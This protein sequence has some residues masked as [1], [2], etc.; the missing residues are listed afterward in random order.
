MADFDSLDI[1]ISAKNE[2]AIKSLK[3][4]SDSV[5][6]LSQAMSTINTGD[7]QKLSSGISALSQAS[8]GLSNIK[9]TDFNKL[10][11]AISRLTSMDSGAMNT[12]NNN[13]RSLS[14][15]IRSFANTNIPMGTQQL[16]DFGMAIRQ[17]GYK[18]SQTA[19]ETIPKLTVEIGKMI[20][21][22]SKMPKVEQSVIDMTNAMANLTNAQKGM[23]GSAKGIETPYQR[24]RNALN[25]T[26]DSMTGL[27]TKQKQLHTST[28]GLASTIGKVYA[29]YWLLF[30]AISKLGQAISIASSLTE[31]QNVVDVS[32]GKASAKLDKFASS[33]DA[34][35]K[36][37]MNELSIKTIASQF[38]AMGKAIGVSNSA[39]KETN[40]VWKDMKGLY[41]NSASS[42]ADVSMNLTKLAS[43][44]A[45]F[46]DKDVKDVSEDLQAVFTGLTRPLRKYGLDLTQT[47]LS[48]WAF[49]QGLNG[50]IKTMTNAEKTLLRYQYVMQRTQHIQSDFQKTSL[51]WHNQI[52]ILKQSFTALASII[53]Q[54]LIY[55]IKPALIGLNQLMA[56]FISVARTISDSLGTIFGWQFE[57]YNSGTTIS[58]DLDGIESGVD[59]IGNSADSSN[60]KVKK[61]KENLQGFD[62]LNVINVDDNSSG[63][64]GG[65]GSGAGSSSSTTSSSE[66]GWKKVESKF[67][68][69][70]LDTLEKLGGAISDKL[71]K[72]MDSIDWDK[73]YGR[74]K[75]FGSGLASFLNGLFKEDKDGN[76]V[77]SALGKTI[78]G[79]LNTVVYSALS[80]SETAEWGKWGDALGGGI[81]AF[82]ET[83][84]FKATANA[85][86]K[87]ADG[88]L[89]FLTKAVKKV[90]W[91]KV[92]Q[93]IAD[94]ICNI[95]WGKLI[96]DFTKLLGAFTSGLVTAIGGAFE[97][98]PI[99]TTIAVALGI[100]WKAPKIIEG[101]KT[102]IEL[103]TSIWSL[104]GTTVAGTGLSLGATVGIA[105]LGVGVA[106][107]IGFTGF[108]LSEDKESH[109]SALAL[110][111]FVGD[112]KETQKNVE[113]GVNLKN[114]TG[115]KEFS[116][117][118]KNLFND[119]NREKAVALKN[120]TG[121]GFKSILSKIFGNDETRSKAISLKNSTGDSNFKNMLNKLFGN[122]SYEKAI[123]LT[124]SIAEGF[125]KVLNKIFGDDKTRNKAVKLK[126]GAGDGNT[127]WSVVKKIF[128]SDS[129][130][131]KSLKLVNAIKNST[132]W[133]VLSKLFGGG[134]ASAK[135]T[136]DGK[137]T[138]DPT[139]KFANGGFPDTADVFY[140]NE[141]G[142]AELVGS[143]GNRTA[144][145]NND[146]I[147]QA[148]SLGVASAVNSVLS[149]MLEKGQ[150]VTVNLTGDAKDIFRVV[151]NENYK[152]KIRTGRYGLEMT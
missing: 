23:S 107:A 89:T 135:V 138:V 96:W 44:M 94:F 14:A 90:D 115:D 118:L 132:F 15:T 98:H 137:T 91:E 11:R 18:S 108:K 149:P 122:G 128:G 37:G 27:L 24:F 49:S 43:D 16:S 148:V 144:V 67:F 65:S 41:N 61:L 140:A 131:S 83:F 13:M 120:Q 146:Q 106:L 5:G 133:K 40:A 126:N 29:T 114:Q 119:E 71:I 6:K 64:S 121:D 51:S 38:Q 1:R 81:N 31:V 4:L 17:L 99:E 42:M 2:S 19:L 53:G 87:F 25:R 26:K 70:D 59:G 86:T 100:L 8:Q 102:G 35:N 28:K 9:V 112:G 80:F 30:R 150:N 46:Y 76:T 142:K 36:F 105:T 72:S 101:A 95:K 39:V 151:Q 69:S 77:F 45:S 123:K 130:R 10:T 152:S 54:D 103:A 127:F 141:N 79:A 125:W 117:L 82:F 136:L 32:F 48:E 55:A 124:N 84:D 33:L 34:I 110:K 113:I 62:K 3:R 74:A 7:F 56:K 88:V 75:N 147:V 73:I 104:L 145:A 97:E 66:G 134:S 58:D 116:K 20:T 85:I 50:N 22:M 139:K 109:D 12:V 57:D 143:I 92:G 93:S 78:A 60:D 129:T 68:N 52:T 21:T 47:T 111:N 63:G